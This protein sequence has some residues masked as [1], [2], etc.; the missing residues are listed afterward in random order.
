MAAPGDLHGQRHYR[1]F[2]TCLPNRVSVV[3]PSNDSRQPNLTLAIATVVGGHRVRLFRPDHGRT[4]GIVA[5][6]AYGD[7]ARRF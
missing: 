5:T 2:A 1:E 3:S 7:R 4:T 6:S